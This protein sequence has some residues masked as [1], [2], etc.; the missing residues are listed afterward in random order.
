M[1]LLDRGMGDTS[2]D[3]TISTGVTGGPPPS[4]T[5]VNDCYNGCDAQ[6]PNSTFSWITGNSAGDTCY[7]GCATQ[8]G[9]SLMGQGATGAFM[10]DYYHS[11][12]AVGLRCLVVGLVV[13]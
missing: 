9:V 5:T 3:W 7:A 1:T 13:L 8:Y 11:I 6:Y 4:G 12:L 2:S 10:W